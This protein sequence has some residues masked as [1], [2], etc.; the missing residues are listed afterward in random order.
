GAG[1]AARGVAYA[2]ALEGTEQMWIANRTVQKA[3]ELAHSLNGYTK[4]CGIGYESIRE[5]YDQVDLIVHNTSVGMHP[6][7]DEVLIDTSWFHE[8]LTVSDLVYN[9]IETRLLREARE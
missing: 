8:G 1:G 3:E 5:I 6:N 9:P 4:A 7:V 2:L